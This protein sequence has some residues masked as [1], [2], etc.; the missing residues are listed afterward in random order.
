MDGGENIQAESLS[1]LDHLPPKRKGEKRVTF[2]SDENM[3]SEFVEHRATRRPGESA[4]S[5]VSAFSRREDELDRLSYPG[6]EGASS[7][8]DMIL[9]YESTAHLD[10]SSNTNIGVWGWKSLS[11]LIWQ[12]G[13]LRR[14]DV[15]NM[16]VLE[17]AARMLSGALLGSRL[18]VLCLEN[19]CLS[20]RPLFTL[21][22][23]LKKNTSLQELCLA[24]NRL[25]SFQDSMQLGDL[26]KHNRCLQCLDLGN[27]LISDE[28]LREICEGLG[29]QRSNLRKL[30]LWDNHLTERG[31]AHLATVLPG[32]KTLETL[33]LGNNKLQDRGVGTLKDSLIANHSLRQFLL[34]S[35]QITCEGVVALAEFVAEC[36]QIQQLDIRGNLVGTGGLLALSLALKINRSLVRVDLDQKP[37]KDEVTISVPVAAPRPPGRHGG[38]IIG[39]VVTSSSCQELASAAV[40]DED[41]TVTGPRERISWHPGTTNKDRVGVQAGRVWPAVRRTSEFAARPPAELSQFLIEMQKDLLGVISDRCYDNSCGIRAAPAQPGGPPSLNNVNSA[42]REPSIAPDHINTVSSDAP[43][44]ERDLGHYRNVSRDIPEPSG[45]A[46]HAGDV[47][48][49]TSTTQANCVDMFQ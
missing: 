47:R 33:D 7:L 14:L 9:Y 43:G 1:A 36:R 5:T 24:S 30:L 15:S 25:N 19:S 2:P 8:L 48:Q 18:T 40:S 42:P 49:V 27:N 46:G 35:T 17:D 38:E 11:H 45:S 3:V 23:A 37:K 6:R 16:P 28:G 20:G 29:A 10:I 22:G 34:A 4:V 32:I 31:M 21:V 13:C 41:I 12:S 39:F 44:H 26:L